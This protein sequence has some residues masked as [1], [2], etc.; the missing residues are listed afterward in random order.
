MC[1]HITVTNK[2]FVTKNIKLREKIWAVYEISVKL[3]KKE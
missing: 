3:F 2:N 1:K